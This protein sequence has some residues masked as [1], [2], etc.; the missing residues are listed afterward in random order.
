MSESDKQYWFVLKKPEQ[1]EYLLQWYR[2]LHA[3][4]ENDQPIE[5]KSPERGLRAELRHCHQVDVAMMQ[6]GFLSLSRGLP[7]LDRHHLAG[8]SIIAV[9]LAIAVRPVKASLP[10]LLGQ[11]T[12]QGSKKPVFSELRFQKLLASDSPDTLLKNLQ[13]ALMQVDK[14]ANPLLL[15][16]SILHW[17]TE[18]Q[19]PDGFTGR[20]RWRYQWAN[21]YYQAV[22]D[23]QKVA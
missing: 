13:R 6:R 20:R 2:A 10:A 12:K 4:D 5:G 3:L 9:T 7:E 1:R 23:Y 21:A 16:D 11:E 8:L 14:Q 15:A 22:F 18:R 17:E 19:N